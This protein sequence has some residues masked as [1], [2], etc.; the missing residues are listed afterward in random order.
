MGLI[1]NRLKMNARKESLS[2]YKLA[3]L[4]SKL[5]IYSEMIEKLQIT[6]ERLT[7]E[8]ENLKKQ[9][10]DSQTHKKSSSLSQ[11]KSSLM[12]IIESFQNR[13][14][15]S[16]IDSLKQEFDDVELLQTS[17]KQENTSLRSKIEKYSNLNP[18]I[19]RILDLSQSLYQVLLAY[20][21]EG[22]FNLNSIMKSNNKARK[23]IESPEQFKESLNRSKEFLEK[24]SES[25]I[26]LSAETSFNESCCLF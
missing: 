5:E 21:T 15:N 2:D 23:I 6:N 14:M 3:S 8:N 25:L 24:V 13:T 26:D 17:I 10:E 11:P 16:E 19:Q 18:I 7:L 4:Q 22:E 20:K 9:L 1:I 12:E